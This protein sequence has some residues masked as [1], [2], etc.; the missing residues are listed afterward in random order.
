M[1]FGLLPFDVDVG[2]DMPQDRQME[3]S[4]LVCAF[5]RKQRTSSL[6]RAS[7]D[8][9]LNLSSAGPISESDFFTWEALICG[10]KDTPFVSQTP[11]RGGSNK[12][13][14]SSLRSS[15]VGPRMVGRRNIRGQAHF[16]T[17]RS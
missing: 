14:P 12:P 15:S 7:T 4:Q 3:C 8:I 1:M 10:P 5:H 2:F 13:V 6:E 11:V 17:F 9:I 16:R